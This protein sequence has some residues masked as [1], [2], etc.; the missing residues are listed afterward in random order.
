MRPAAFPEKTSETV[1][2]DTPAA[3]ATSTLVTRGEPI[4]GQ[5]LATTANSRRPVFARRSRD[6]RRTAAEDGRDADL[7]HR[8]PTRPRPQRPTDPRRHR[9]ARLEVDG[10]R[11][12][13]PRRRLAPLPRAARR[14]DADLREGPDPDAPRHGARRAHRP[15]GAR[16]GAAARGLRA[17][18]ARRHAGGAAARARHVV[19]DPRR[20]RRG[21]PRALR[22]APGD[23]RGRR[24]ARGRA[25]GSRPDA[26]AGPARSAEE[27][28][29]RRPDQGRGAGAVPS[30]T[31][32][33]RPRI[34]TAGSP[35]A[36]PRTRSAAAA[37]SSAIAICVACSSRPPASGGPRQSSTG[38]SPAQPIATS[39]WPT[40]H[41]AA[42]RVGDDDGAARAPRA[43][44]GPRRPGRAG[45]A[46]RARR[47]RR[48]TG[49]RPAFAQTKPWCVRQMKRPASARTSSA[50]SARISST[51]RGSLPC[52][53]ASA[54]AAAPGIT[55]ASG[56]TRP[57]AL[58]TALCA[59][60]STSA[61][62][63]PGSASRAAPR[64]RA[65]RRGRRPP[66]LGQAGERLRA[67]AAHAAARASCAS[68][69]RVRGAAPG[70]PPSACAGPR[71]RRACRRRAA[72]ERQPRDAHLGAGAG[73]QPGV[74]GERARAERRRHDGGR[75]QQQRV[76][77]RAMPVGDDHDPLGASA[78]RGVAREQPA[79]L[80]R[81]ERRAVA[82]HE[83]HPLGAA[84]AARRR[85]RAA[86]PR[87]AP[88]RRG[89]RSRAAPASA[90]AAAAC[91]SAV[92]TRTA[93]EAAD[94]AERLQHVA[95]HR[96]GERRP[97]GRA[98]AL[99]QAL[100]RA[101]E[102]LDRGGRRWCRHRGAGR[103]PSASANPSVSRASRSRPAASGIATSVSSVGSASVR[104][105][106]TRP[107]R[108]PS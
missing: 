62:A 47:R 16:G 3:F 1:D 77:P 75:R 64:R 107:S 83:Q 21:R 106:A 40:R 45:A 99:G 34:R 22:H 31:K 108:S 7:T 49:R 88:P 29:S 30:S 43:A 80:G 56:T 59:T 73:R 94:G 104:A 6:M 66:D 25:D 98:D 46:P 37:A 14:P 9:P 38:S 32:R 33:S 65:A 18:A 50:L 36:L 42:E 69:A 105:S 8:T 92:T 97:L 10:R 44:R 85:R 81:V 24:A 96:G 23:A 68:S 53:A 93:V 70:Q 100:L 79:D 11:A 48:W 2:W 103:Y 57:S 91:G 63:S 12:A 89:R 20:A 27:S 52:S 51:S 102:G 55:P 26:G 61:R 13:R 76:R 54:G 82:G 84:P 67:E 15:Q 4:A 101:I 28:W 35:V 90:A 72:S 95:D 60:T 5:Q 41:G 39:A 78:A 17:H 71:G 58:A 87:S 86:P 74:P 19:A